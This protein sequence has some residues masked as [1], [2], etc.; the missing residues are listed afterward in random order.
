[1]FFDDDD[2]VYLSVSRFSTGP[3][4]PQGSKLVTYACEIDLAT[5]NSLTPTK[6]IRVSTV[7][8]GVAE[9]PHI[10][11]R[12]VWYYL[13]TADGGTGPNHQVWI[14]R[15]RHPLGPFEE[16]PDGVN[17]LVH[18]GPD[19]VIQRTGHAD[20]VQAKDGQ[21]WM[22]MLGVRQQDTQLAQL[23]RETFLAP[24]EWPQGGWPV[25][26]NGKLIGTTIEGS[27]PHQSTSLTWRD[28]FTTGKYVNVLLK[29][30]LK[31]QTRLNLAGIIFEH[32]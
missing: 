22:V 28:N 14:T 8:P 24:V 7:K 5:G 10:C 23:G 2:R 31:V 4:Q 13:I 27:L 25:V 26:N 15:S 17:P 18:N 1:L 20:L 21:W 19:P 30:A 9:G 16:A 6:P 3:R 29:C 12:G 11:K 32:L